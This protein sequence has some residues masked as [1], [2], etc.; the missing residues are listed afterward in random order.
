MKG[1]NLESNHNL[2]PDLV[3]ISQ[4]YGVLVSAGKEATRERE[5]P[6]PGEQLWREQGQRGS[7]PYNAR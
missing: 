4:E 1:I 5:L 2:F 7:V 6:R 3:F